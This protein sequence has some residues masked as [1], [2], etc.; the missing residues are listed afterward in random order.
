[1]K[2][3]QFAFLTESGFTLHKSSK[4]LSLYMF[5]NIIPVRGYPNDALPDDTAETFSW[6]PVSGIARDCA[7]NRRK[8]FGGR[9]KR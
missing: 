5:L 6:S 8:L 9:I 3:Q 4:I 1:V 7:L 2:I